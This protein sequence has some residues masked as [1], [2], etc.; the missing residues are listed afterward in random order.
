MEFLRISLKTRPYTTIHSIPVTDCWARAV[1]QKPIAIQKWDGRT[2]RHGKVLSPRL[3]SVNCYSFKLCDINY[4]IVTAIVS[5]TQI[6]VRSPAQYYQVIDLRQRVYIWCVY[7][8][9]NSY[10]SNHFFPSFSLSSLFGCGPKGSD[11]LYM[12]FIHTLA[13]N[14]W[15][16]AEAIRQDSYK[17]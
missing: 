4:T 9:L 2:D 16:N 8:Y 3:S 10:D 5:V 14:K 13:E 11:D 7:I 6:S 12:M 15:N 17:S 1:T